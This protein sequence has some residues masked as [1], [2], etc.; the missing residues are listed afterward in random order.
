M[1]KFCRSCEV[2]QRVGKPNQKVP[3]APL[4]P[5]PVIPFER[6]IVDCVG[7]LPKSKSGHQY[8]LTVMCAATRFPEAIPLRSLKA[9]TVIKDLV[10]FF[11]T[12]GLP[13]VIQSD[14]GTNFTSK[15]FAQVLKELGIEQRM[16]SPY[17][18]ESQGALERFHQTLKTMIRAYCLQTGKDWAEGLPF[19]LFAA[20]E[21][22]QESLGFSP[23]ELVFGHTVRGPL[24]LLYE[25]LL[26]KKSSCES[27]LDYVSSF[28][29]R[30]HNACDVAKAHLSVAQSNMKRQFDKKSVRRNFH[31]GDSV[32]ALLPVPGA[33]LQA[34]FSGP[35]TIEQ[36]LSETD[37]IIQTPDRRRKT[38]VCHVNMLKAFMEREPEIVQTVDVPLVSSA[39]A[40][41][42]ICAGE[43]DCAVRTSTPH[44]GNSSILSDLRSHLVHLSEEQF[45]DVSNLM[46][47][48]PSLFSDVP[49]KTS[50]LCH[51][52][53]VG[54]AP[55][56]KQHPYRVNPRKREIMKVEVEYLLKHGLAIPSQSPWSSPCLLVP[57]QDSTYR[58]CTDY[59]KVN[60]LTKPDSFPLPR[61]E[62]CID[63]VGTAR[64]V[65]KID[66]LKG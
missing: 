6:L 3:V 45:E 62:D 12:F 51:D 46:Q 66:L 64:Y 53:E 47:S 21:A 2:C 29:E 37:Y 61:I 27:L 23:A 22:V 36:K 33:A 31:V 16:S 58:F 15:A 11:T 35:Y 14:Q 54:D 5:I 56:V 19:L 28:R 60:N 1:A 65:T 20:R 30:L 7:P 9:Q 17:H 43:E 24:K 32:L 39:L 42:A 55:P 38:R 40:S 50:V 57:K 26:E 52:I 44:L 4:C 34:K 63:R 48:F 59:R 10:K 13:R 18:P 25:H 8:V 49:G 41:H